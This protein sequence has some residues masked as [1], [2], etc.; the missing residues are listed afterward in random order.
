MSAERPTAP[1]GRLLPELI[2]EIIGFVHFQAEDRHSRYRYLSSCALVCK[3]FISHS[4]RLLFSQIVLPARLGSRQLEDGDHTSRLAS[5]LDILENNP[6]IAEHIKELHL[7]L[8]KSD[9]SWIHDNLQLRTVMQ[10]INS[11]KVPL[12][13]LQLISTLTMAPFKIPDSASYLQLIDFFGQAFAPYITTL[14]L[15]FIS[16]VPLEILAICT[17]LRN[18]TLLFVNVRKWSTNSRQPD[19]PP[20]PKIEHLE[21]NLIDTPTSPSRALLA[22][23]FV[24]V[25]DFSR[26]HSLTTYADDSVKDLDLAQKIIDCTPGTLQNLVVKMSPRG[27]YQLNRLKATLDVLIL[28]H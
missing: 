24:S 17:N 13:K 6:S 22:S 28:Q 25:F 12:Q 11:A 1:I 19:E 21:Y 20:P 2:G 9:P 7:V 26:L 16:D 23:D 8:P 10:K 4:Q 3:A 14:R 27:E 15:E 18:L 5:L